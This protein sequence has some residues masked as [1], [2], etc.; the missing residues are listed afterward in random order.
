[1][2]PYKTI[3]EEGN[4]IGYLTDVKNYMQIN[5]VYTDPEII[6]SRQFYLLP[7]FDKTSL[8][9]RVQTSAKLNVIWAK[10]EELLY[11]YIRAKNTQNLLSREH[12]TRNEKKKRK[13]EKDITWVNKQF[14]SLIGVTA[15]HYI[16]Y[17]TINAWW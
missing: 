7:N 11:V 2:I 17:N 12:S 16:A 14:M 6:R 5:Q 13:I 3:A 9:K 1:M 4:H 10:C 15:E 8:F